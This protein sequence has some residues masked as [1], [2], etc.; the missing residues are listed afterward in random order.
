MSRGS[1]S[2]WPAVYF[3]LLTLTASFA[4]D[5]T[6]PGGPATPAADNTNGTLHKDRNTPFSAAVSYVNQNNYTSNLANEP[7]H[8]AGATQTACEAGHPCDT[9]QWC[10]PAKR[11]RPCAD[12]E[13]WCN[14]TLTIHTK[15]AACEQFCYRLQVTKTAACEA[16]REAEVARLALL[17]VTL[18][19]SETTLDNVRRQAD[20]EGRDLR[21]EIARLTQLMVDKDQLLVAEQDKVSSLKR[22]FDRLND[23]LKQCKRQEGKEDSMINGLVVGIAFCVLLLIVVFYFAVKM[24]IRHKSNGSNMTSRS[25]D[26]R[27]R[28]KDGEDSHALL[29][30]TT[31]NS[32]DSGTES[33]SGAAVPEVKSP[34]TVDRAATNFSS[35][36]DRYCFNSNGR[37]PDSRVPGDS[38]LAVS[39]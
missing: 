16:G 15:Y 14:V 26:G 34:I 27:L 17:N 22:D 8:N 21:Q 3:I 29:S 33:L 9:D 30:V 1:V 7:G 39:S 23:D 6:R 35:N 10:S 32:N 28:P 13:P 20:V 11:C 5:T 38:E 36:E 12:L 25:A 31:V 24:Y 4:A 2:A 18:Q 19:N 37:T